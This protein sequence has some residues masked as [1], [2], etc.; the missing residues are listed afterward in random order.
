MI[1]AT[2]VNDDGNRITIEA[3]DNDMDKLNKKIKYYN[4]NNY[5]VSFK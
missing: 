3:P 1:K 4:I 5:E 2:W